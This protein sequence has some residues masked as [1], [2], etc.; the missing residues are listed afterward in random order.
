MEKITH[1]AKVAGLD[2][3]YVGTCGHQANC[4]L[5]AFSAILPAVHHC[6]TTKIEEVS[7]AECADKYAEQQ[8]IKQDA[9]LTLN[10]I[11]GKGNQNIVRKADLDAAF[12]LVEAK[13]KEIAKLEREN[14]RLSTAARVMSEENEKLQ[15]SAQVNAQ[16]LSKA[17]TMRNQ[18]KDESNRYYKELT[19]MSISHTQLTT[20]NALLRNILRGS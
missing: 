5:V 9:K 18:A 1:L 12:K 2:W 10:E 19:S 4:G 8:Y 17:R 16:R 14:K 15:A 6:I 3:Q 11:Y 20:E 7:C 13:D